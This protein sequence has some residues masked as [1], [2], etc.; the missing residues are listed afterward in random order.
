MTEKIPLVQGDTRPQLLF[1]LTDEKNNDEPIDLTGASAALKMREVGATAL[2]A[3]L[4]CGLLPGR[5]L[6]DGTID[7][8]APYDVPGRGGRLYMD[9]TADALDTAG[10]F[11]AEIEITFADGQQQTVYDVLRFKVRPQF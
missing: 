11:E 9:W 8:A 5:V 6:D 2:K 10:D 4:P 7:A 3:T 1:S